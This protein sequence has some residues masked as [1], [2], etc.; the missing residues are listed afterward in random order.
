MRSAAFS[1]II[2]TQAWMWADTRSGMNRG[3][4]H[5]QALVQK[6]Y[7]TPKDIVEQARQAIRP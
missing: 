5:A 1:A 2:G 7:A 4:D 6:P 3:I